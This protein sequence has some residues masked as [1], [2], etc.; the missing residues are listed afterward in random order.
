[1]KDNREVILRTYSGVW[2]LDRKLYSIEGYKL[3]FPISIVDG[4]YFAASLSLLIFIYK[5]IPIFDGI[6]FIIRFVVLPLG[7]T[8]LL[9]T[10]KLDGKYPHK[11]FM[12]YIA[13]ILSPKKYYR[14]KPVEE[15]KRNKVLFDGRVTFKKYMSLDKTELLVRNRR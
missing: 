11:F 7:I 3:P 5:L 2:K 13:F 1:M 12:D 9:T 4:A 14:F 15:Y 10:I 6:N 8:K